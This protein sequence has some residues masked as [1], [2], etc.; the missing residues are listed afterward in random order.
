MRSWSCI[1]KHEDG[2]REKLDRGARAGRSAQI[3][4]KANRRGSRSTSPRLES[5]VAPTR[6]K[7]SPAGAAGHN[8]AAFRDS[9]YF[10]GALRQ[11]VRARNRCGVVWRADTRRV[12]G[13]EVHA[14]LGCGSASCAGAGAVSTAAL[15]LEFVGLSAAQQAA[16]RNWAET[17]RAVSPNNR[18]G[19]CHWRGQRRRC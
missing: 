18:R 12:V 4:E 17:A 3:A 19:R 5:T 6:P 16:M 8:R 2:A 9:G 10:A 11:C 7:I 14:A 15:R 1:A 13:I